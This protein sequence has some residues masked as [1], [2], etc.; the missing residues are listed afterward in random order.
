METN[1]GKLTVCELENGWTMAHKFEDWPMEMVIFRFAILNYQRVT[2]HNQSNIW[3]KNV[4][5]SSGNE[6]EW[7]THN[8]DF[9]WHF[10]NV[11][12]MVI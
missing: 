12:T 2:W 1:M 3:G 6:L 8:W 11:R 10:D 9:M 5:A 7:T 4:W